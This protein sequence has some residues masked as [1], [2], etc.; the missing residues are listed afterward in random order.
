MCDS[1]EHFANLPLVT[2][3]LCW[4]RFLENYVSR[5]TSR[6]SQIQQEQ[7]KQGYIDA[8]PDE[9]IAAASQ[10]DSSGELKWDQVQPLLTE[11]DGMIY[12]LQAKLTERQEELGRFEVKLDDI[13]SENAELVDKLKHALKEVTT[14]VLSISYLALVYKAEARKYSRGTT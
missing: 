1:A 5:L 14:M 4:C 8:D 6:L 13:S 10:A 7:G 9:D 11:Y 2:Q 12:S 3:L